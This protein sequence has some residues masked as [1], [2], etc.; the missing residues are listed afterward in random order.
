MPIVA[1]YLETNRFSHSLLIKQLF[2]VAAS[3]QV[4]TLIRLHD[5]V[6]K[7]SFL[8]LIV[9]RGEGRVGLQKC[10]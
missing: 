8:G 4:T 9:F 3:P 1:K 2:P 5:F 10:Q 6:A 7:I